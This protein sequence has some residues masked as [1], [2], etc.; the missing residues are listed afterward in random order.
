VQLDDAAAAYDELSAGGRVAVVGDSAGGTLA[1]LL[2]SRL[3]D[4]GAAALAAS[5]LVTPL[6]HLRLAVGA[7]YQGADSYLNVAGG[8]Q[9]SAAFLGVANARAVAA[10]QRPV[11]PAADAR[12]RL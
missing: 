1:L 9:R 10:V 7:A 2:A 6:V 3:R 5:G 4:R 11:R 8:R 12:A